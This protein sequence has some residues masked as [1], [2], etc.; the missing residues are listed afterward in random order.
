MASPQLENGY[1][2]VANELLEALAK[3]K[4]CSYET[5]VL[6][7]IIRKTYGWHK[8]TDWISLSQIA[9]GTDIRKPHVSRTIN[10]LK[11]RNIIERS[12]RCVGLQKNHEKWLGKLPNKAI[13]VTQIGNIVTQPGTHKRNLIQK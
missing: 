9:M 3:I 12:N 6:L 5:R 2:M 8:K 4:L 7:F 10:S 1:T 11:S 13:R